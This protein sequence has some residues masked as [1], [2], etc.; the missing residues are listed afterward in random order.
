MEEQKTPTRAALEQTCDFSANFSSP[1]H[2]DW[3]DMTTIG[4]RVFSGFFDVKSSDLKQRVAEIV[5]DDTLFEGVA[6][7]K[8]KKKYCFVRVLN[9]SFRVEGADL[10]NDKLEMDKSM[11]LDKV[12]VELER[13]QRVKVTAKIDACTPEAL[14]FFS[15]N[16]DY[17]KADSLWQTVAMTF[18]DWSKDVCRNLFSWC[19][20]IFFL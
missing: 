12:E 13:K 6:K 9:L 2:V 16:P 1:E 4:S 17:E 7:K 14:V 18:L 11:G 8:K 10:E 20:L 3:E 19:S 5:E 15:C